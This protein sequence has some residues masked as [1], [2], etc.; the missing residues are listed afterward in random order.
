MNHYSR[1]EVIRS[2]NYLKWRQN[3]SDKIKMGQKHEPGVSTKSKGL[4]LYTFTS[5]TVAINNNCLIQFFYL[6]SCSL[7]YFRK[8]SKYL[9]T[10]IEGRMS[11]RWNPFSTT[12]KALRVHACH[13]SLFSS[14]I[15]PLLSVFI[16]ENIS[17]TT[18]ISSSLTVPL[19][20]VLAAYSS[21]E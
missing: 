9:D 13:A 6:I 8:F 21:N 11:V 1:E 20:V 19:S 17:P 4:F 12:S 16:T 2:D 18:F 3:S 7:I 10:E 15:S 5:K 14:S